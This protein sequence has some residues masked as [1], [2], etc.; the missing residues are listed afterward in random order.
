MIIYQ[1][2]ARGLDYFTGSSMRTISNTV[3]F[4][5]QELANSRVDKFRVACV[6]QSKLTEPITISIVP[7]EV[8]YA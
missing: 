7:M 1:L 3:V 8:I 6:E 2:Q 5:T 4:A